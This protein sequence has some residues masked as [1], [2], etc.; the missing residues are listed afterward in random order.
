MGKGTPAKGKKNN[1]H[2]IRCR[3]CDS[4]SWL[5]QGA[6]DF[7]RLCKG[8]NWHVIGKITSHSIILLAAPSRYAKCT[9]YA[10]LP[11]ESSKL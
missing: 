10:P 11:I 1:P 9:S 6:V 7:F 4:Y 8:D 5:K 2:H 3:R